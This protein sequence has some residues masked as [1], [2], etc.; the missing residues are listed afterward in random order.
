MKCRQTGIVAEIFQK[1][2]MTT[3]N[4]PGGEIVPAAQRGV[5]DCAEWVGGVEDLRLGLQS[6][7]KYHYVPGMHESSSVGELVINTDVWKGLAPQHQEA[8]R[9]GGQARRSSA[10]G[11]AGRNRTPT[12]SRRC[13]PSTAWRSCA[14]RPTS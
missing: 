4:M 1:M 7:W 11:R 12:P 10:G 8:I 9:L 13:A 3:V 6:V 5:I 2:G 14:R